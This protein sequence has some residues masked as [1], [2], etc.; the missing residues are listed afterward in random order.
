MRLIQ[1]IKF[2]KNDVSKKL[3]NQIVPWREHI[4][5]IK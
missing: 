2:L 1:L 5:M 4:E 3:E